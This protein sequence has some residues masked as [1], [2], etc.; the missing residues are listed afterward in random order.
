MIRLFYKC[1][2]FSNLF[3]ESIATILNLEYESKL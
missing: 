2:S 1:K 3:I